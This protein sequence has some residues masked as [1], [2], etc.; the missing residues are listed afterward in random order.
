[1]DGF[2]SSMGENKEVFNCIH[3]KSKA[4]PDGMH[5]PISREIKGIILAITWGVIC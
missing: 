3:V 1:M 4:I 2:G 5:P